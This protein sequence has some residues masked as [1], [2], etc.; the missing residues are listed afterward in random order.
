MARFAS[1]SRQSP[2]LSEASVSVFPDVSRLSGCQLSGLAAG[3]R[4]M[5]FCCKVSA[6]PLRGLRSERNLVMD[7]YHIG[8]SYSGGRM[9]Y[10]AN[11]HPRPESSR[12]PMDLVETRRPL[13]ITRPAVAFS[14]RRRRE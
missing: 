6:E 2:R 11:D 4:P 5:L 8:D 13:R 7:V 12:F 14:R 1:L 10:V 3:E 9:I